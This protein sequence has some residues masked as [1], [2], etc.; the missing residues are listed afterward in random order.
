M[1]QKDPEAYKAYQKA[2]QREYY[3]KNREQRIA[4]AKVQNAAHRQ[5][6]LSTVREAKS[7]PCADCKVS[8]PYY[9]MQ[10]DHVRGVKLF[11]IANASGGRRSMKSLQDEIDKCDVVCANCHAARTWRRLVMPV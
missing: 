10:F 1:P 5:R 4:N 8:Y 9:V 3:L 2:Y 6:L 11:N 7:A